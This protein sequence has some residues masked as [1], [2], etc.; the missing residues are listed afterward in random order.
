M[1]KQDLVIGNTYVIGSNDIGGHVF[2][3]GTK[4][5]YIVDDDTDMPEFEDVVTGKTQY[6]HVEDISEVKDNHDLNKTYTKLIDEHTLTL[7]GDGT[8]NPELR[9]EGFGYVTA[10]DLRVMAKQLK[11]W[12]K[13]LEAN[14]A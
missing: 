14:G 11:K 5:K 7:E 6:V 12:A 13:G 10:K 3:K 2:K 1:N 4:V 9:L 8:T